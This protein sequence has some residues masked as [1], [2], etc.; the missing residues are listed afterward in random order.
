M[1]EETAMTL[2]A[3]LA[4]LAHELEAIRA[5]LLREVDGLTQA[6]ADWRPS[7]DDWSLG[8]II[9]HLTLAEINTGKLTSKLL[10]E[11]PAPI[12]PYPPD[13]TGFAPL[14]AWPPGPR[15]APPIVRPEKGHPIGQLLHDMRAARE[16]THQSLARLAAVD[17]RTLSW[18][19]FRL[20]ELDLGQFWMLQSAHDRD[21][22][23][24][25]RRIKKSPGF[26][27]A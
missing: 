21:H 8:E 4:A 17:P 24:Q 5:E 20:G 1:S 22:L 11:T 3:A 27:R 26:P 2:P 19:H 16:R 6:Q 25:L 12:A 15:E 9:H 18:R 7:P 10:K 23:Q 14:P 13:L